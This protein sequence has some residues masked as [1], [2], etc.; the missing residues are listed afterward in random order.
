L[1]LVYEEMEMIVPGSE[2]KTGEK[3]VWKYRRRNWFTRRSLDS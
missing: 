3:G 2:S 1:L